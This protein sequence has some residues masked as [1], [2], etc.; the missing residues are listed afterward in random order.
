MFG[1]GESAGFGELVKREKKPD[2]GGGVW[3]IL[4]ESQLAAL[5]V[6]DVP[7]KAGF[8]DLEFSHAERVSGSTGHTSGGAS[9]SLVM[10]FCR[11][12]YRVEIG[13]ILMMGFINFILV[14]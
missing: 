4:L 6:G 7:G 12:R 11:G 2:F 13:T 9:V 3:S 14:P 5:S 10:I 1:A 8:E